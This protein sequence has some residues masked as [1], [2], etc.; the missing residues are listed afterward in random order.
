[1]PLKLH[2]DSYTDYDEET[3]K[4]TECPAEDVT[5]EHSLISLSK[6]EEKWEKP[7]MNHLDKTRTIAQQRDYYR[8]MV[9]GKVPAFFLDRVTRTHDKAIEDYINRK[10]TA[11]VIRS[12]TPAEGHYGKKGNTTGQ[13]FTSELIYSYMVEI[14]IPFEAEKWN[15][16]RLITLIRVCGENQK[17]KKKMGKA[18]TAQRN[19]SLNAARRRKMG[20]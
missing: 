15:L 4:L 11:T 6:W 1:M 3:G 12:D 10:H 20:L 17:P 7:F 9:I 13:I 2:L 14:G 19:A 16:N 8:C 5:L 18:A